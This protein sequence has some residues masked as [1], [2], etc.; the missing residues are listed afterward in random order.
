V[1][2]GD[3]TVI[4]DPTQHQWVKKNGKPRKEFDAQKKRRRYSRKPDKNS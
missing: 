4:Q 1:K 2:I 3:E